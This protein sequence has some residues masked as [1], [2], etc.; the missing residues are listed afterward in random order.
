MI[1]PQGKKCL[2]C[3]LGQLELFVLKEKLISPRNNELPLGKGQVP[4]GNIC[5]EFLEIKVISFFIYI[6]L[7][8]IIKK[9]SKKNYNFVVRSTSIKTM[10][11]L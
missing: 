3:S 4:E 10:Q 7:R 9:V 8:P 11:K 5:F 2:N 1:V 6:S